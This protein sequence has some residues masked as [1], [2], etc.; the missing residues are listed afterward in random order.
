MLIRFAS[1]VCAVVA[2]SALLL[3]SPALAGDDGVIRVKSPYPVEETVARIKKDIAVK[4]ILFFDDI[5]QSALAAKAGIQLRPS[6]LLVFGNPPLGT[7]FITAK[8]EAGLDWPVRLL[9]SQDEKGDVWA[10]YTDFKWIA[11]R[12]G[13]RDRDA[14]FATATGVVAS[15]TSTIRQ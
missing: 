3:P 8:A 1:F 4:G 14:E 13:I 9:V 10:I 12:H 11:A 5:D 6:R 7:L 2:A 15:I